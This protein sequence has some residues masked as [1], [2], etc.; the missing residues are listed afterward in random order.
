MD[1]MK[2]VTAAVKGQSAGSAWTPAIVFERTSDGRP[3]FVYREVRYVEAPAGYDDVYRY[4]AELR[5]EMGLGDFRLF[6]DRR[7]DQIS[8]AVL[9]HLGLGPMPGGEAPADGQSRI[10]RARER[11]DRARLLQ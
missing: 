9:W 3:L 10:E 2:R 4:L 6:V 1:I 7:R 8:P 5:T 11:L